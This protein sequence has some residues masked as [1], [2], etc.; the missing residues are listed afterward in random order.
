[1]D[2]MQ[3]KIIE[4]CGI[5][6]TRID[7]QVIE[8]NLVKDEVNSVRQQVIDK[9]AEVDAKLEY[10]NT[11]SESTSCEFVV[12]MDQL[13]A[14]AKETNEGIVATKL[15]SEQSMQELTTKVQ[16]WAA[17]FQARSEGLGGK[18]GSGHFGTSSGKGKSTLD[19][20]EV[21]V[22]KLPESLTKADFRFWLD[23]VDKQLEAI[24]GFSKPGM[25]CRTFAA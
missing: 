3:Q 17:G 20:K 16:D 12:L 7:G 22:W 8:V 24:H 11:Q 23:A 15:L 6:K 21:N 1:M 13:K 4:E 14:F 5:T 19:K 2:E 25:F 18:G 9:M 10:L